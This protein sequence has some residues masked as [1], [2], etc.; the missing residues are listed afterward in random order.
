MSRMRVTHAMLL[1]VIA[2]EGD[3]FEA[4]RRL[5]RD[6]HEDGRAQ[7][8]LVRRAVAQYRALLA[9]GVVERVDPPGADG[10]TVRLVEGLQLGLRA[11]PAAVDVR[12]RRLRRARPGGRRRTPSTWSPSSRPPSRTR[13]RCSARRSTRRAAR[14]SA[15]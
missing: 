2:R 10:R 1:N 8:R 6:N 11:E 13:G 4:M 12:P 7:V 5:L 9:A 15:R 14:R 3:P